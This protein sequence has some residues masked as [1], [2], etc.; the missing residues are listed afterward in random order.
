FPFELRRS[1]DNGRRF[2]KKPFYHGWTHQYQITL[3]E[4]AAYYYDY[5]SANYFLPQAP[6]TDDLGLAYG[7]I[8]ITYPSGARR[9]FRH[10]TDDDDDDQLYYPCVTSEGACG[11]AVITRDK[12]GDYIVRDTVDD[13]SDDEIEQI[14]YA[15]KQRDGT[16]YEFTWYGKID[17][18]TAGPTG[19]DAHTGIGA[20][21]DRY[22]NQLNISWDSTELNA[23][24]NIW[25]E[26]TDDVKEIFLE[27]S[28]L[29]QRY[30]KAELIVNS[31]YDDPC[32]I[33]EYDVS[34][35]Y[36]EYTRFQV[37]KVGTAAA[38]IGGTNRYQSPPSDPNLSVT[39]VTSYT[40][41][42]Q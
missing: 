29:E 3:T 16:D 32:R 37:K 15:L 14:T 24:T 33:V 27:Y 26:D 25:C 41:D 19:W 1:F 20:I 13:N 42:G 34:E 39:Y 6:Y 28:I 35:L 23:V 18:L 31:N 9:L 8:W 40:Y 17:T 12:T 38:F 5:D 36:G 2:F 21:I 10:D 4:D 11:E 7:D 22:G 30:L